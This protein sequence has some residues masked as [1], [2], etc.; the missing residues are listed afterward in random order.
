MNTKRAS[1][2]TLFFILI[3]LLITGCGTDT[4]DQLKP[5]GVYRNPQVKITHAPTEEVV[6]D[7]STVEAIASATAEIADNSQDP[8]LTTDEEEQA[9]MDKVDSLL[10]DIENELDRMNT[11][12]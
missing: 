8:E 10:S 5:P 1:W 12:P 3:A 7:L 11:N 6:A 4:K 9:L 2:I